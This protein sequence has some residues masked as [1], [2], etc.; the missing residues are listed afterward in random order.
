MN[1]P[2]SSRRDDISS[3]NPEQ[4]AKAKTSWE[5][6]PAAGKIDDEN[7]AEARRARQKKAARENAAQ[8][9]VKVLRQ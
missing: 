9:K 6:L 7:R 3:L 1:T 4:I 2:L 5:P 8:E